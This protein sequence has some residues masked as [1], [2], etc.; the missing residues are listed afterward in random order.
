MRKSKKKLGAVLLCIAMLV[1]CMTGCGSKSSDSSGKTDSTKL[2]VK[3]EDRS[4]T[5]KNIIK[6]GTLVVGSS[7]DAPFAYLDSSSNEFAGLDADII[8][9]IAAR[10]GIPKVEM[11]EVAF[12]NLIVELNNK[13]IDMVTDAMYIK[14]ERLEKAYF[15]DVWY[16]EGEALVVKKDS[17]IDGKDALKG[18]VV[19]GQTGTAFLELAQQWQKD[20]YVKEVKV[21]NSQ[22][23]LMTAVNTGKI[24]ACVTDGIV[25]SYTLQQNKKLDLKVVS[26]YDAEAAGRIG[27]AIRF[28]D[29]EFLD[30]VN[31]ALNSMKKDG[32]LKKILKDNYGLGDDYYVNEEDGATKNVAK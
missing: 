12:D 5:L 1:T 15:T 29:K 9:E 27:A 25:A 19:G 14:D 22:S 18:K 7:N 6:K 21:F 23:E 3:E 4:D 2:V 32:T 10:L 8:R 30:E 16:K 11:K 24:E 26:P 17:D 13:S 31:T 20:G 28:E